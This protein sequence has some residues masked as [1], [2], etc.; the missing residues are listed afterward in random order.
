MRSFKDIFF[1]V[2]P[3]TAL[4]FGGLLYFLFDLDARGSSGMMLAVGLGF[5]CGAVF[6]IGIG[7]FVRSLDFTF[8]VDPSVDI[9]T[10][11]QLMLGEMGYRLDN[12]FQKI[13]TF[14]PTMRAGIF[15]DQVRVELMQGAVRIEGPRWHLECIRQ[16]LGV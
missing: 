3:L 2:F 12:Q 9:V 16:K 11:L 5:G 6:G 8:E 15:A 13:I 4:V 7:Y 1:I 14:V 10:R